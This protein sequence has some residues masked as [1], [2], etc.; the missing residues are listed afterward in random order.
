MPQTQ[1]S[2]R[3]ATSPRLLRTGRLASGR[4]SCFPR[5]AAQ[6]Q[7]KPRFPAQCHK[8]KEPQVIAALSLLL[9]KAEGLEP[10]TYGLKAR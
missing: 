7:H 6:W 10:S 1:R 9:M 8:K 4:C 5:L 3:E 2:L